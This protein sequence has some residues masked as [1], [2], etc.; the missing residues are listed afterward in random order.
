MVAGINETP[1]TTVGI[2]GRD[3][4]Y[5]NS[6]GQKHQ[7]VV[8]RQVPHG[9]RPPAWRCFEPSVLTENLGV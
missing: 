3:S 4:V 9:K 7:V 8:P 1:E 2:P 6:N 5:N